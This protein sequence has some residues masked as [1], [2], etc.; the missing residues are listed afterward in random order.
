[1]N[2]VRKVLI[3]S[4]FLAMIGYF[5]KTFGVTGKK[6]GKTMLAMAGIGLLAVYLVVYLFVLFY[7]LFSKICGPFHMAG[8]DWLYFCMSGMM[9]MVMM[10]VGSIFMTQA[11]LFEAKDNELLLSMPIRPSDILFSRMMV[12]YV[13]NFVFGLLVLIPV[14][15]AYLE[16]AGMKEMGVIAYVLLAFLMPLFSITL[17]SLFGWLIAAV[18][19]RTR[20]KSLLT[21]AFSV[22]FLLLYFWGYTKIFGYIQSLIVNGAVFAKKIKGTV[23][24]LYYLGNCVAEGNLW[25]LLIVAL[26][27]VAPFVLLYILLS[28]N[29][30]RI[31][32][33]KRGFAKVVYREKSMKSTSRKNALLIKELRRLIGTP[34]YLMNSGLGVILMLISAVAIVIK[35]DL[36]SSYISMIPMLQE[37]SM[38]LLAAVV[39]M[40]SSMNMITAPSVSLEGK[41]FWILRSMPVPTREILMAKLKLQLVACLPAV[42]VTVIAYAYAFGL[43]IAGTAWLLFVSV[44]ANV[45]FAL[46]GLVINL[47]FPKLDAIS[48]TAAVKQSASVVVTMLVTMAFV[49]IPAG[50]YVINLTKLGGVIGAE[51]FAA[52]VCAG[53]A[54]ISVVLYRYLCKKGCRIFENLM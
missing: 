27:L 5:K 18:S 46:L 6:K 31:T 43:D 51:V 24:P 42:I 7:L 10:F 4:R 12:L 36:I 3:R 41:N 16:Y 28:K 13:Y 34:V 33:T 37:N 22:A 21:M 8:I 50:I 38:L 20:H 25:Q 45:L 23:L 14:G 2:K 26:C 17:A 35:K 9:A 1:M 29:F 53:Y 52:G 49:M 40:M 30:I 47:K 44:L 54:L 15:Y 19:G 32:T 11:Q 39:C 48:D